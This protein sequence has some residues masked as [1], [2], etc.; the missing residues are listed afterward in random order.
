MKIQ[1]LLCVP[2]ACAGVAVGIL[3]APAQGLTLS[4]GLGSRHW[5][6]AA[7]SKSTRAVAITVSQSTGTVRIFVAGKIVLRI[8]PLDRAM[9]W[10]DEDTEPPPAGE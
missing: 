7:I 2:L 3:D 6:A 1:L 10:R 9:K 4:K 5:A 8:E